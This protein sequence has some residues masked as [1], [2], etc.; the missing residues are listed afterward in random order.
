M[1][2]VPRVVRRGT[3]FAST[4]NP[5]RLLPSFAREGAPSIHSFTREKSLSDEKN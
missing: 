4:H 5:T 2:G 1:T 3:A